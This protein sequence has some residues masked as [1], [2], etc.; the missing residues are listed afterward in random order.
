[1][2]QNRTKRIDLRYHFIKDAIKDE[3]LEVKHKEMK[4]MLADLLTKGLPV[5][6][7][8]LIVMI[9]IRAVPTKTSG[10]VLR[11]LNIILVFRQ[12][13]VVG[14]NWQSGVWFV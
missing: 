14:K 6:H 2:T 8:Y 11:K 12:V 10:E 4:N 13:L 5:G 1:M 3:L 9:G 7:L